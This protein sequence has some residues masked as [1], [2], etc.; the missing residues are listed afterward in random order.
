MTNSEFSTHPVFQKLEQLISRL[1][2]QEAIEKIELEKQD[3]FKIAC[4]FLS[5][6]LKVSLPVL[7]PIAELNA[8]STEFE[9][10]LSQINAFLGNG[11]VGHVN[12]AVNNINSAISYIRNFP[13][14]NPTGDFDFSKVIS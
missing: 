11:N 12:N 6:R 10:A 13:I 7:V 3:F 4:F 5:E 2:E 1:Q 8:V 9:N 14:L